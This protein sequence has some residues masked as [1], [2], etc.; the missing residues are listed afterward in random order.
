MDAPVEANLADAGRRCAKLVMRRKL[1]ANHNN[2][3]MASN[4]RWPKLG[5]FGTR[6]QVQLQRKIACPSALIYIVSQVL[7]A[8]SFI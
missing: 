7:L 5:R 6:D 8:K 3:T 2:N 4:F 1:A